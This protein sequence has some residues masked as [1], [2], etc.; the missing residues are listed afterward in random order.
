MRSEF[1]GPIMAVRTV[2]DTI[3]ATRKYT[4][5]AFSK[6]QP[7]PIQGEEFP[8]KVLTE[9]YEV[10]PDLELGWDMMAADAWSWVWGDVDHID[11]TFRYDYRDN[12]GKITISGGNG[13]VRHLSKGIPGFKEAL[14]QLNL[15]GGDHATKGTHS[16][17]RNRETAVGSSNRIRA[18][19]VTDPQ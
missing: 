4:K 13:V 11:V 16:A 1:R 9:Y 17:A 6:S 5:G 15:N 12:K 19:S 14:S 8:S 3:R 10:Y 2:E 18:G 7:H